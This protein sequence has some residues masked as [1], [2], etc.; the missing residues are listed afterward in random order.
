MRRLYWYFIEDD[1]KETEG[2]NKL[3]KVEPGLE[4]Q[5]ANNSVCG[6][7]TAFFVL[8]WKGQR[9]GT[10]QGKPEG[11]SQTLTLSGKKLSPR[12]T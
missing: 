8:P 5:A 2:L 9:V 6:S 10:S 3:L 1:T 4:I 11:N 12:R 7:R